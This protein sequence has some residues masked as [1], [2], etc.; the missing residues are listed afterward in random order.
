MTEHLIL[1]LLHGITSPEAAVRSRSADEVTDVHTGLSPDD[2]AVLVHG[3]VAA[4]MNEVDAE[5]QESQLHALAE[6]AEWHDMPT[7]A[8]RRLEALPPTSD[9]SQVEYLDYLL[10]G[11]A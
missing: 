3:L 5:C 4:R 10:R 8:V 11:Q 6:L 2:V 9:P 1:R 7:E